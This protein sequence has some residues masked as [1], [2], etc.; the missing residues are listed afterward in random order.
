MTTHVRFHTEAATGISAPAAFRW[1]LD[2][3]LAVAYGHVHDCIVERFTPYRILEGEVLD[4]V[5]AGAP[6]GVPPHSVRVLDIGCGPGTFTVPLAA[7]GFHAVGIDL[8]TPL[9]DVARERRLARRLTNLT[10]RRL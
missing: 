3:C 1:A 5:R 10:F 4:L 9:L 8:Y 2:R 7:A 6:A